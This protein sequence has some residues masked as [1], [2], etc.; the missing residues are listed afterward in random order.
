MR[1]NKI[2]GNKVFPLE[3]QENVKLG[4]HSVIRKQK[5]KYNP[6]TPET[7]AENKLNRDFYATAPNQKWSTDVTELKVPGEK[8][9]LYLR[10]LIRQSPKIRVQ[11]L[12]FTA[13]GG[14]S[15]REEY[16]RES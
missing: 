3:E 10:L 6:P 5:K 14:I 16:F 4:I 7:T 9:K 13:T 12:C 1:R 8:K 15:I 2:S 11:S